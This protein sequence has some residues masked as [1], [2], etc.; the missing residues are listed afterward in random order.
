MRS[1]PAATTP[2][3]GR[4]MAAAAMAAPFSSSAAE[5]AACCCRSREPATRSPVSTSRRDARALSRQAPGRTAGGPRPRAAACGGHD[6]VRPRPP[7]RQRSPC[8]F[9]SFHHL[10]T[11][12][13]QLACLDR[14]R[15]H[16]LPHG[17]LVLDL[18]N[19]DSGAARASPPTSRP[20]GTRPPSSSTGLLAGRIRWW[21]TV[22]G[23]HRSLQCNDARSPTRSSRPTG[24]PGGSLRRSSSRYVFRYELEHLLV[25]SGFRVVA[26]YGDYDRS[27]FAD[28]SPA[29]IVV[30]EPAAAP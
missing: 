20:M 4:V 23:Y 25:R 11:V 8:P 1:T 28:E 30:A 17:T 7:L 10:R 14:C 12:E 3:S 26:L 5:P 2:P 13:Q 18:L 15:H 29:M 21:V 9:G 27:P 6:V 22:I 16:L 24:R 19:P